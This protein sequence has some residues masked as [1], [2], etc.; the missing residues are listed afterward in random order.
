MRRTIPDITG[1]KKGSGDLLERLVISIAVAIV[2]A[3]L[4]LVPFVINLVCSPSF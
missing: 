3:I 2:V 4:S 1:V